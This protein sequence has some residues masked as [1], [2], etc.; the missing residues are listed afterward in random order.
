M[1]SETTRVVQE[2]GNGSCL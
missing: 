2:V 1:T